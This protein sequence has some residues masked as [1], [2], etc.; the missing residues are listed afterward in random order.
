MSTTV[1]AETHCPRCGD[2]MSHVGYDW[3]CGRC[4]CVQK[5]FEVHGNYAPEQMGL[6]PRGKYKREENEDNENR[7]TVI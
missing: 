4:G 2:R 5:G 6:F 1:T 7:F 3:V